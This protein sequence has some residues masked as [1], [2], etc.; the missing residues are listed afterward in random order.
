MVTGSMYRSNCKNNIITEA[1]NK[2]HFAWSVH[3]E[4]FEEVTET[5][6]RKFSIKTNTINGHIKREVFLY[7]VQFPYISNGNR[8]EQVH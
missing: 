2:Y 3:H 5:R 7:N 6:G 4:Q 1:Y 8:F